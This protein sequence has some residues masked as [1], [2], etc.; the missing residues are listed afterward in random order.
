V[1]LGLYNVFAS[2]SGQVSIFM[3]EDKDVAMY[4]YNV[5]TSASGQVSIFMSEDKD[6][7]SASG[8]F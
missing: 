3:S 4:L 7:A 5:F 8:Q 2:A 1:A 6:V